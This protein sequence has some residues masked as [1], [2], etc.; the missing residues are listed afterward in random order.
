MLLIAIPS[1][2]TYSNPRSF[3][4][5]NLSINMPET[6]YLMKKIQKISKRCMG[7]H[8]NPLASDTLSLC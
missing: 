8:P 7:A 2:R 1:Q 4:K 6:H 5:L 3:F